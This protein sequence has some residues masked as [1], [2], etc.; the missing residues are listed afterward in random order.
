MDVAISSNA[1]L[2]HADSTYYTIFWGEKSITGVEN[3]AG[4]TNRKAVGTET[5]ICE[6][7]H[8]SPILAI[9]VSTQKS[10]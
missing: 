2:C 4:T 9:I 8:I 10:I 6:N 7:K 5:N 1:P 3:L